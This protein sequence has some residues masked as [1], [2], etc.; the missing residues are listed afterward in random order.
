MAY[1]LY[2]LNPIFKGYRQIIVIA[3]IKNNIEILFVSQ[4]RTPLVII[5]F[6][7]EHLVDFLTI[8]L[9]PAPEML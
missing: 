2:N 5:H 8:L 4:Y 6:N 7:S 9:A 1:N 3:E